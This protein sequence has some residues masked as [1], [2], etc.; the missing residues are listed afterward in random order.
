MKDLLARPFKNDLRIYELEM[1]N[2]GFC[3]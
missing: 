1:I 2:P 3:F